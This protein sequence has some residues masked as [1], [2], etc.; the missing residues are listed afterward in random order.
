[1]PG[2]DSSGSLSVRAKKRRVSQRKA[3][4][5][6]YSAAGPSAAE[7]KAVKKRPKSTYLE[8]RACIST[9]KKEKKFGLA[10]SK[11]K[12]SQQESNSS[13]PS[14]PKSRSQTRLMPGADVLL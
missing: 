2:D 4:F 6:R 11:N 8:R 14:I 1:M 13:S 3:R 7:C 10:R 12:F 5:L 9:K